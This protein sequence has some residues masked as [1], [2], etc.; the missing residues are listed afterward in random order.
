MRVA[1][2]KDCKNS[3]HL[4][5][6]AVLKREDWRA[7]FFVLVL[8]EGPQRCLLLNRRFNEVKPGIPSVIL[9]IPNGPPSN[10]GHSPDGS[11]R[12]E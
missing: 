1:G 9:S 7:K 11:T 2:E 10:L 12:S 4:N 6:L 3:I 5:S 8:A